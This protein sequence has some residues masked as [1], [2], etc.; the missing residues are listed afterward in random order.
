MKSHFDKL[1]MR[2]APWL[3][4]WIIRSIYRILRP[5]LVNAEVLYDLWASGEHV[6]LS[7]WHDQLLLMPPVY[8]GGKVKVLI[9]PSRDGEMIARTIAYFGMGAVR[10]SSSRGGREALR[11][12]ITLAEE[13]IDL[14]IT[15]DGPKGPRHQVKFGAVQLA[16]AT[17][18]AIVP[19]AFACSRGHRFASWDRF[20]LPYPWGK[21]VYRAG[22][23]LYVQDN[24]S[25][26]EFHARVQRAMDENTQAAMDFLKRYDLSAV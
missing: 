15:P 12:M 9:S 11:E 2:F 22:L 16:R 20:L 24:E 7:F 21:A 14:G 3:A 13:P 23:P 25:A 4:A 19:V 17:G 6:I 5:E 10:G 1:L 18:R 8:R 26:E